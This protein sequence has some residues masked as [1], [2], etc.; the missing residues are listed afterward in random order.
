MLYKQHDVVY[1]CIFKVVVYLESKYFGGLSVMLA[2]QGNGVHNQTINLSKLN[3][4][5]NV[6]SSSTTK[7]V[8]VLVDIPYFCVRLKIFGDY[9]R[10]QFLLKQPCLFISDQSEINR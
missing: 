8:C 4:Q 9:R 10:L 7:N 5:N 2:L 1:Y 3:A 6:V